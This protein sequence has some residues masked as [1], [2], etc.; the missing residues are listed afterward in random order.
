MYVREH[1]TTPVA[2]LTIEFSVVLSE[3]IRHEVKMCEIRYGIF[4]DDAEVTS[5]PILE[6]MRFTE[7][8]I[9]YQ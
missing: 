9:I 3:R 4:V 5:N 6:E 1:S 2:T 8:Q 7:P